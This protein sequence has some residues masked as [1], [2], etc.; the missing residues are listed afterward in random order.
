M[1]WSRL[2]PP[3]QQTYTGPKPPFYFF[4]LVTL[5]STV[6]SLIHILAADGGAASI[7]GLDVQ[8]EG[9]GNLIAMFA[10]WGLSQLLLAGV[11]WLVI[12]RYR[13]LVP[14]MLAVVALEQALR[15]ALGGWK[16]LEVVA[17]PP[18]ALGSE[19]LLPL[20]IIACLWSLRRPAQPH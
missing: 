10:Q 8:V 4:I 2:L 20:A 18:G 17:P 9:G 5:L 14:A 1:D 11:Y 3:V 19:L 16:P 6:R 15:L 13:F 7:A 12:G